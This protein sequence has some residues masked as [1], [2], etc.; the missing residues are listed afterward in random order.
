MQ[1][2]L[3]IVEDDLA[4]AEM[5]SDYL[6]RD[7]YR[8]SHAVDG[9]SALQ[10]F[11]QE[12]IDLIVLDLMLP[13]LNGTEFLKLVR[14]RS[15]VPVL[16][17]SAKD[18]ELDK[19]LGLGFGADDYMT[20]PFSLVELSARVN[21]ALR[22]ATVYAEEGK[23]DTSASPQL[24]IHELTLDTDQLTL[25]KNGHDIRLTTKEFQIL[26]LLLINPRRAFSKEQI[27]TA[28]WNEDYFGDDNAINVHIS[29]LR[30]KI[31]DDPSKP[32]YIKTVWGIGYKLGEF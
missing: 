24:R 18:G 1:K 27:Y 32:R 3:L 2:H 10:L 15:F 25:S 29:R 22:R 19:A 4:I 6:L 23:P 17:V 30:D 26:K 13:G 21:S 8:I 16:I 7:G 9:R 12:K 31:E 11:E 20:K 5:V 28:V 14:M